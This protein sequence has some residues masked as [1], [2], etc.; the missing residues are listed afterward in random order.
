[1]ESRTEFFYEIFT[2]NEINIPKKINLPEKLEDWVNFE[3]PD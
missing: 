1:M 3:L 2:N